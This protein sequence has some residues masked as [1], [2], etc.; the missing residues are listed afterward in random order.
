M[1]FKEQWYGIEYDVVKIDEKRVKRWVRASEGKSKSIKRNGWAFALPPK[2]SFIPSKLSV[3]PPLPTPV[4]RPIILYESAR[5]ESEIS[6]AKRLWYSEDL[7]FHRPHGHVVMRMYVPSIY[8][9][10]RNYLLTN[11]YSNLLEDQ[12]DEDLYAA[13]VAG[14]SAHFR[15]GTCYLDLIFYGYNSGLVGYGESIA[16]I[17]NPAKG[18]RPDKLRFEVYKETLLNSYLNKK[19]DAPHKQSSVLLNTLLDPK[20]ISQYDLVRTLEQ[21][22]FED[23]VS[24]PKVLF[25][26]MS[27]ESYVH[28]NVSPR[29]ARK[30]LKIFVQNL[31]FRT[32]SASFVN[33]P[34]RNHYLPRPR[35]GQVREDVAVQMYASNPSETNSAI[36]KYWQF[37]MGGV[38]GKLYSELLSLIAQKPIFHQLR[39]KEQLGY[40]VWSSAD[41][42][43]DVSGF[44][45][46]VQSGRKS[47]AY[48]NDRIDA[49]ILDFQNTLLNMTQAQFEVYVETLMM[50][51]LQSPV[52]MAVQ[53]AWFWQE[54]SKQEY[55]FQRKEIELYLLN[56]TQI[57]NRQ[58]F[59]NFVQKLFYISDER[60]PGVQSCETRGGGA[61]SVRVESPNPRP[62]VAA[63]AGAPNPA[64]PVDPKI[65]ESKI[66][67]TVRAVPRPGGK[68]KKKA[69]PTTPKSKTPLIEAKKAPKLHK[70][71]IIAEAQSTA[72][73]ASTLAA[74]AVPSTGTK[75]LLEHGQALDADASAEAE[76]ESETAAMQRELDSLDQEEASLD[77]DLGELDGDVAVASFI[78]LDS[79]AELDDEVAVS[80]IELGTGVDAPATPPKAKRQF[81]KGAGPF[82]EAPKA[83]KALSVASLDQTVLIQTRTRDG[84]LYQLNA[85]QSALHVYTDSLMLYPRGRYEPPPQ[86][87]DLA[88]SVPETESNGKSGKQVKGGN[89]GQAKVKAAVVPPMAAKNTKAKAKAKPAKRRGRIAKKIKQA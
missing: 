53:T 28:G 55:I 8:S 72:D 49:F 43:L 79:E 22:Q 71:I 11:I 32:T 5:N 24:W 75:S 44:K 87:K 59:Q 1:K 58:G 27:L 69:V 40:I 26:D 12:M 67:G 6:G 36:V 57:V 16:R 77:A 19:Y 21:I 48:L 62:A 50:S 76:A 42:R 89:Q 10:A 78:E 83:G 63:V 17:M 65:A 74:T 2:S 81:I 39:T 56:A 13:L 20:V 15:V 29:A 80:F 64:L 66:V 84:S 61:L 41:N 70:P 85:T 47:A 45:V 73:S 52:S 30:L 35:L 34:T 68:A 86:V 33:V 4:P 23:V 31:P 18:F 25:G 88:T 3:A 46:Q 82:A 54:I 60:N 38:E 51:K 7:E 37:G 9:S 14:F